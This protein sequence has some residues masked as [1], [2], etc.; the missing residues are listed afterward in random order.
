VTE[1]NENIVWV[2]AAGF[3]AHADRVIVL[4]DTHRSGFECATC[5]DEGKH[6]VEGREVST[7]ACESCHGEGYRAKAGNAELKIRCSDCGGFGWVVC[8]DCDGKGGTIVLADDQ[9]GRPTTG[10]VVSIGPDVT[11]FERGKKVIYPSFAGHAYDLKGLDRSG[12]VVEVVLVILRDSEI[13]S[14]MYGTLE[15]S[16]VKRSAALNT[17]A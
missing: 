3:E 5:L 11:R 9:K 17:A 7:V 6:T 8:P 16:Q 15:S 12:K 4:Q 14:H 1:I 13:L 10:T 2:G